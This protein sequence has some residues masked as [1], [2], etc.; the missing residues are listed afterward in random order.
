MF[1]SSIRR[2]KQPLITQTDGDTIE[3]GPGS[4]DGFSLNGFPRCPKTIDNQGAERVPH[5]TWIQLKAIAQHP[6]TPTTQ[7]MGNISDLKGSKFTISMP[8][9]GS[10]IFALTEFGQNFTS[11][12]SIIESSSERVC[13]V[14]SDGRGLTFSGIILFKTAALLMLL[15]IGQNG[16]S[17]ALKT[18]N[19]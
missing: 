12:T 6:S 1:L 11:R 17:L 9:D 18:L 3:I 16:S 5:Q 15:D 14:N 7:E 2:F 4:Y 13:Y 10:A 8:R 19:S